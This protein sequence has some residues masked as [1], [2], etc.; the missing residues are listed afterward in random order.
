MGKLSHYL[1][2]DLLKNR[3]IIGSLIV[4]S[5][6]G[7]GVFLLESQAEKAIIIL[8][9]VTLLALP[10]LSLIFGSIYYYN[11]MDFIVLLLSQPLNRKT[12]IRSFYT[13]IS[14]A[15]TLCYLLGIGLPLLLFYPTLSTLILIA[16]GIM[17]IAIFTALSLWICTAQQDRVR[18][19]GIALILWI[20]F[21]F[22]FDG[23][24]LF[25]MFYFSEYPVEKLILALSFLNPL[26]IARIS[27]IMQTDASALLG[28]S[29]AVFRDFFGSSKGLVLSF[30]AL[31]LWAAI[32]FF[33]TIRNF[34]KKDL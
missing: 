5:L 3:I 27:V 21:A 18:G 33:K 10:L 30:L 19:M 22:L 13:G 29:G 16:A 14:F 7:W 9:Q 24:L 23:I 2:Q 28:L 31:F 12:V 6:I 17:L 32:A 20:G 25:L 34:G 8:M 15:F 26:D 11:S 1:L 4:L